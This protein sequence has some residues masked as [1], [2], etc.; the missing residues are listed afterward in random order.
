MLSEQERRALVAGVAAHGGPFARPPALTPDFWAALGRELRA[1]RLEKGAFF[2]RPGEPSGAVALV[3][4]G[5]LR[6]Y[7]TDTEGAEFT[8]A[9]RGPGELVAAFAELLLGLPS[10]THIQAV[11]A[12][13][14]L[15]ADF[16]RLDRAL[17][18]FPAWQPLARLIAEHFYVVKEKR[19]FEL[20]QLSAE[21]RYRR[22]V[23]DSPELLGRL[24]Q[25]SV[26]SYLGVTP[27]ALSRIV[28]RLKR[29]R[30]SRPSADRRAPKARP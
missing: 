18:R 10:R 15:V 16:A 9:F 6:F 11:E 1:V 13:V 12:S 14:V 4:S 22:F 23:A 24:P 28:S 26:A 27:V 19:E 5:L 29:R 17:A 30:A 2:V 3:R 25:Y 7:Y 21:E 8:K 20:L